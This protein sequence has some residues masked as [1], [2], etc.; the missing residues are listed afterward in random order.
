VI[1]L[2]NTARLAKIQMDAKGSAFKLFVD[3]K[4]VDSW[5]DSRL[6]SGAL[7]FYGDGDRLPKLLALSFTFIDNAVSR[8]AVVPLP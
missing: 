8:T 1:P 3:D 5:S 7:G 4:P 2:K 6:N